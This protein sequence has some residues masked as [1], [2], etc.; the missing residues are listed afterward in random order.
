MKFPVF[1]SIEGAKQL[2]ASL[3]TSILG[4]PKNHLVDF[5]KKYLISQEHALV[6]DVIVKELTEN[7]E[8]NVEEHESITKMY[9]ITISIRDKILSTPQGLPGLDN[10]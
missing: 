7:V 6:C 3:T 8:G 9:Q 5:A 2:I 1:C 10:S 4:M